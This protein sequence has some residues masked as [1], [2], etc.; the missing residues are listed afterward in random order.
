MKAEVTLSA[1]TLQV[2]SLRPLFQ[3]NLLD[4]GVPLL[5]VTRTASG[6]WP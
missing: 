2:K 6:S 5:D 4:V 3:M 1:Q